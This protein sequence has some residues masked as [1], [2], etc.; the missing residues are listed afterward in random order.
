MLRDLFR[1]PPFSS[2]CPK[3]RYSPSPRVE[4]NRARLSW[5]TKSDLSF[6]SSPSLRSGN[7]WNRNPAITTTEERIAE[8]LQTLI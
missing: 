5:R 1:P 7:S 8:E 2:P 6:V 3:Y 4:A